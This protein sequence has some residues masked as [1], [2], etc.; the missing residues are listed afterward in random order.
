M[1]NRALPGPW[2]EMY[3]FIMG[4]IPS[5]HC[6]MVGFNTSAGMAQWVSAWIPL[7]GGCGFD[8]AQDQAELP[9]Y[10]SDQA[11]WFMLD[12]YVIEKIHKGA[13]G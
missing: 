10:I 1:V 6:R 4:T 3:S 13:G 12:F 7:Y 11:K 5:V 8:S 2:G 9:F